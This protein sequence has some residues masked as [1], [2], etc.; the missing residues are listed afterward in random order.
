MTTGNRPNVV[1][2]D[3]QKNFG[4]VVCRINFLSHFK[5]NKKCLKVFLFCNFEFVILLVKEFC[6]LK[7]PTGRTEKFYLPLSQ[8]TV[9]M[10][11]S[12]KNI[13]LK[14]EQEG[15]LT[16]LGKAE[17]GKTYTVY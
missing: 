17:K 1:R 15:I 3:F 11:F 4:Q 6:I 8:T 9:E 5:K 13:Y 7:I 16:D 10:V 14:D 12:L 2:R